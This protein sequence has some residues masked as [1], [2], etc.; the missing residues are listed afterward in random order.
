MRRF[1][2]NPANK[3]GQ[4]IPKNRCRT[5][6]AESIGGNASGTALYRG[7]GRLLKPRP[8]RLRALAEQRGG[9]CVRSL[10]RFKSASL[11]RG[12]LATFAPAHSLDAEGEDPPRRAMLL[13]RGRSHNH[14]RAREHTHTGT[15]THKDT[16]NC[17]SKDNCSREL[18]LLRPRVGQ[19]RRRDQRR[20]RRP[21]HH[22]DGANHRANLPHHANRHW[23]TMGR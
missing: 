8:G 11:Q 18:W 9:E 13:N 10:Q 12:E 16:G 21:N 23:Q 7:S 5:T 4:N 19:D 3:S 2:S 15:E 20:V 1:G 22:H 14:K 6:I 17:R